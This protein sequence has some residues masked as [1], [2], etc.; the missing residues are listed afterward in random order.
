M[1]IQDPSEGVDNHWRAVEE[2]DKVL[3]H[4]EGRL[5]QITAVIQNTSAPERLLAPAAAAEVNLNQ[6]TEDSSKDSCAPVL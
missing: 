2:M 4:L 1:I 6:S 3:D 5:D